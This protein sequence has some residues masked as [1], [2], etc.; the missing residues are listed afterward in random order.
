MNFTPLLHQ[1]RSM[2]KYGL[3]RFGQVDPTH[4]PIIDQARI[5]TLLTQFYFCFCLSGKHMNVCRRVIVWPND[6]PQSIYLED[7]WHID[8]NLSVRF[9][10]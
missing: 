2:L 8:N 10:Q 5:S 1:H 6:K 3:Q 7:G 4:S 9:V